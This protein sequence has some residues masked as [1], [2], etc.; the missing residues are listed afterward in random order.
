MKSKLF[1]LGLL[2]MVLSMETMAQSPE[3]EIIQTVKFMPPSYKKCDVVLSKEQFISQ[4]KNDPRMTDYYNSLN[5]FYAADA[6]LTA[7]S[8]ILIFWPVSQKLH[9]NEPNWNLAIIG[10]GCFAL[11]I[12]VRIGFH[13][14]AKE[15]VA[16]YN[17][18]YLNE[19]EQSAKVDMEVKPNGFGLI[20]RF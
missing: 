13:R 17:S 3:I 1:L 8:G 10:A 20:M 9:K 4:F 15:A 5:M 19:E 14:K 2:V 6:L 7:G 11:T 16:F 12:P 18:G